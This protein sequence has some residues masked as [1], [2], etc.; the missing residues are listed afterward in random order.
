MRI[1]KA[2]SDRSIHGFVAVVIAAACAVIL[3][4][5]AFLLS[6]VE[7]RCESEIVC[8]RAGNSFCRR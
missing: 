6:R 8:C 7:H 2:D 1:K 4:R 3:R 5:L